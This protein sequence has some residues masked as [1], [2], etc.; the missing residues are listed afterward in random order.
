MNFV[1]RA[2]AAVIYYKRNTSLNSLIAFLLFSLVLG[3]GMITRAAQ[4]SLE[5]FRSSMEAE[6][7][8]I[9]VDAQ[10]GED[11]GLSLT[12]C[13]QLEKEPWLKRA[14]YVRPAVG[15]LKDLSPLCAKPA[16]VSGPSFFIFGTYD[17]AELG[18]FVK[19][20]CFLIEGGHLERSDNDCIL[21]H[22]LLAKQNGLTVGS[23]VT[24]QSQ[25]KS[26]SLTVKGIYN[27]N[28]TVI[29]DDPLQT[30]ANRAYI[31]L[32]SLMAVSSDRNVREAYF[33]V[34][35]PTRLDE[36]EDRL[37]NASSSPDKLEITRDDA[38]YRQV[39]AP[40]EQMISISQGVQWAAI[41]VSVLTILLLTVLFLSRRGREMG[42]LISM[43][44][45][46]GKIF[47]QMALEMLITFLTGAVLAIL[48]AWLLLPTLLTERLGTFFELGAVGLA[49][50]QILLV[51]GLCFLLDLVSGSIVM[52]NLLRFMP[53]DI[54]AEIDG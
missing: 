13:R 12:D 43:G 16:E 45:T 10:I 17:T 30:E 51:L 44:E 40:M 54:L 7:Q 46:K 53:R 42:V 52:I 14:N 9:Q 50:G 34:Q 11:A 19:G 49:P 28:D 21:L 31:T 47:L 15:S 37:R 35:A 25:S 26:V 6:L 4:N 38:K 22:T 29:A 48:F 33:T 23:V 36:L 32:D 8:A 3:A 24:L 27:S 18:R 2:F 39:A 41:V 5:T 20:D 1:K